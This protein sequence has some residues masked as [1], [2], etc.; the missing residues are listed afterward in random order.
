MSARASVVGL[1]ALAVGLTAPR[2][3]AAVES[4][5]LYA[6]I[7]DVVED[8]IRAEVTTKIVVELERRHPTFC[9][10]FHGAFSRMQSSYWGGVPGQLREGVTAMVGDFLYWRLATPRGADAGNGPEAF[11]AFITEHDEA[12]TGLGLVPDD[13]VGCAPVVWG[14]VETL[15][16]AQCPF[17]YLDPEQHDRDV[18]C[19]IARAATGVLRDQPRLAIDE[20]VKLVAQKA[21][22]RDAQVFQF[23]LTG[24]KDLEVLYQKI[25]ALL[26]DTGALKQLRGF[27]QVCDFDA[28][29]PVDSPC[30]YL[31]LRPVIERARL[32]VTFP[33][34]RAIAPV[35]LVD[36]HTALNDLAARLTAARRGGGD[37]EPAEPA[38]AASAAVPDAWTELFNAHAKASCRGA[39]AMAVT[40]TVFDGDEELVSGRALAS[41]TGAVC[42]RGPLLGLLDVAGGYR[43]DVAAFD[44]LIDVLRSFGTAP[45]E[46]VRGVVTA[47]ALVA[48]LA[49]ARYL[50]TSLDVVRGY[51]GRWTH[52]APTLESLA[53]FLD[54]VDQLLDADGIGNHDAARAVAARLEQLRDDRTFRLVEK[55]VSRRDYRELALAGLDAVF[56]RTATLTEAQERFLAGFAAYVL[57]SGGGDDRDRAMS[58]E[59]LRAAVRDLLLASPLGGFATRDSRAGKGVLGYPQWRWQPTVSVRWEFGTGWYDRSDDGVRRTFAAEALAVNVPLSNYVG[60][61]ASVL[62]LAGPFTELAL[63]DPARRYQD[64]AAIAIELVKPRL[65]LWFGLPQLT[66]RVAVTVG[67][68][69][70]LLARTPSETAPDTIV[71]TIDPSAD[72]ARLSFGGGAAIFF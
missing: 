7:R 18:A 55:L 4:D 58:K 3:A 1:A 28:A 43:W 54:A 39:K 56:E 48:A 2:A 12:L 70:S 23:A 44:N 11:F 71:Y 72:L 32:V 16:E 30:W 6:E 31:D 29:L 5:D 14:D 40:L 41:A 63:R 52:G 59:A 9:H 42:D 17:D 50:V 27:Q 25:V 64:T 26:G 69:W 35:A 21:G 49:R 57:D 36:A 46:D 62:D 20:V 33:T 60:V 38:G 34:G 51:L 15:V 67:A 37:A 66:R 8:V 45:T 13:E 22:G 24:A 47:Q 61:R 65:E 10:Y 19:A 68:S 53:A